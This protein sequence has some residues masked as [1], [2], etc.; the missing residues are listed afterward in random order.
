MLAAIHQLHYLPWLRYFDKIARVDVFIVLD[1]VQYN[2]NGWQNRNRIKTAAGPLTLTVPIHAARG[3]TLDAVSIDTTQPWRRKHWQALRQSYAKTPNF[4]EYEPFFEETYGREWTALN[5]LN[6]HMLD[7]FV[8]SLGIGT[9][10][11]YASELGAPGAATERLVN[12]LKAVGAD[13][14]YSGAYALDRYLDAT[15]LE[16]ANIG[17]KLQE[18]QAPVYPQA[19]GEFVSDLSIVDLLCNRGPA[20]LE[21]LLTGGQPEAHHDPT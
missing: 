9:R 4:H 12:L 10:I 3:C 13:W 11:V 14:Y 1:N 21:V 7:Q 16:A 18:W 20:S 19:H 2:K 15:L 6:R 17:L 5:A 8:K